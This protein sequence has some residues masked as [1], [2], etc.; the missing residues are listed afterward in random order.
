MHK[1]LLPTQIMV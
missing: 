1:M